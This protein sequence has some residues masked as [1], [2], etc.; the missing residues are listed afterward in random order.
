M[1]TFFGSMHYLS[2]MIP[3]KPSTHIN[4]A[5][6]QPFSCTA[7]AHYTGKPHNPTPLNHFSTTPPYPR[8]PHRPFVVPYQL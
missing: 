1:I 3:I 6:T 8:K 4:T 5:L 2:N 7:Q